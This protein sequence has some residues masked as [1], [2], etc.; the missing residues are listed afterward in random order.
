MNDV[1]GS[2]I[3]TD[4]DTKTKYNSSSDKG[5][6]KSPTKMDWI[7]FEGLNSLTETDFWIT[8]VDLC[9]IHNVTAC[10]ASTS[11]AQE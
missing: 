11:S 7:I 2:F 1:L 5:F 3:G 10:S 6:Y 8:H 4:L 9:R